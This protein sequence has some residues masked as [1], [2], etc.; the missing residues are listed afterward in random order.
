MHL[1]SQTYTSLPFCQAEAG[2][3]NGLNLRGQTSG[4]LSSCDAV[5]ALVAAKTFYLI[6]SAFPTSAAQQ[7]GYENVPPVTA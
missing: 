1:Y 2:A 6:R 4:A 3:R 7:H 5:T